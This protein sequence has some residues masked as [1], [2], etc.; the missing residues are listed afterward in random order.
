MRVRT[1]RAKQLIT[2]CTRWDRREI[3]L[4]RLWEW[5]SYSFFLQSYKGSLAARTDANLNI[6]HLIYLAIASRR[7]SRS[8]YYRPRVTIPSPIGPYGEP[9]R[10]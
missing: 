2:E 3:S 7:G 10:K 5:L 6:E 8:G 1:L 9:H 4:P